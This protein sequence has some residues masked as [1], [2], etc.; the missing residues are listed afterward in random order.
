MG[1]LK[2]IELSE[3]FTESLLPPFLFQH[4]LRALHL[5]LINE[6]YN[7]SQSIVCVYSCAFVF[8]L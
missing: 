2:A 3:V 8:G 6:H 1:Q 7:E 4:V 5:Q